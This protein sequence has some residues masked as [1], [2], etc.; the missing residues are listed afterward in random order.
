MSRQCGLAKAL[1]KL[2]YV[3]FCHQFAYGGSRR[4]DASVQAMAD[5]REGRMAALTDH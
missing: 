4:V 3:E 5:P 2:T 1:L